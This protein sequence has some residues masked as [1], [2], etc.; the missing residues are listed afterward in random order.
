[1][2]SARSRPHAES[3]CLDNRRIQRVDSDSARQRFADAGASV[4]LEQT[5]QLSGRAMETLTGVNVLD[6]NNPGAP[7]AHCLDGMHA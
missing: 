3:C 6:L 7:P 1:M 2:L 4:R 5:L